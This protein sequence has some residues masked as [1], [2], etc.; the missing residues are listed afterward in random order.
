M[1]TELLRSKTFPC[2]N[3]KVPLREREFSLL[4]AI[5]VSACGYSLTFLIAER[6]GLKGAGLFMVTVFIGCPASFL[7]AGVL[8]LLLGWV[9][10]LPPR[11]ERD[12]GP[13]FNDGGVLHIDSPPKLRKGPE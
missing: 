8:G 13:H 6:M 7:V 9:F 3:C 11:L 4:L 1:P 2:P 12:P 5:P 10:C